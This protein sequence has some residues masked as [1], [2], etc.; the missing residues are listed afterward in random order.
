MFTN[1][2]YRRTNCSCPLLSLAGLLLLC[3]SAFAENRDF[4]PITLPSPLSGDVAYAFAADLD[5]D[6]DAD[7]FSANGAGF[8]VHRNDGLPLITSTNIYANSFL[9]GPM[10]VG[11]ID[12]DG[13]LDFVTAFG[14]GASLVWGE[15]DGSLTSDNPTVPIVL[16]PLQFFTPFLN[17]LMSVQ[18]ADLDG[19]GDLDIVAQFTQELNWYENDGAMPTPAFTRHDIVATV[20][21]GN[22]GEVIIVDLN[23]DGLPDILQK[24]CCGLFGD[25]LIWYRNDGAAPFPTFVPTNII[26]INQGRTDGFGGDR[27]VSADFYGFGKSDLLTN[28]RRSSIS[29]FEP[30]PSLRLYRNNVG[31]SQPEFAR[32]NVPVLFNAISLA[33]G[34]IDDDGDMDIV[35]GTGLR[36]LWYENDGTIGNPSFFK[37][38]ITSLPSD[39]FLA[40]QIQ[41]IDMD[42]DGRLDIFVVSRAK[43]EIRV[44]LNNGLYPNIGPGTPVL[45][46]TAE[47]GAASTSGSSGCFIATAAYGTPLANDIDTLRKLRDT[48]LLNNRLGTAFVDTY[49]RIS[50]RIADA[51]AQDST[52]KSMVRLLLQIILIITRPAMSAPLL[53]LIVP[54]TA[55]TAFA[56]RRKI[57]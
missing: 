7:I 30:P 9:G 31:E 56:Y 4:T 10:A 36:P 35:A 42:G 52:L 1:E 45:H 57:L 33:A 26:D 51:I 18:M 39:E 13:D 37:R 27:V 12:L 40:E 47:A 14:S 23:T 50:P 19:D 48:V 55:T 34:D 20:Q 2:A 17:I 11:D 5:N 49:Y 8:W 15:N 28:H 41:A 21:G 38:E 29:A 22:L 54:L 44:Y 53:L 46:A 3:T 32:E 43:D 16:H 6:G 25:Q 24:Y